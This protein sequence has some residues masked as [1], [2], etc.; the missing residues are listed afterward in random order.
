MMR[1]AP[2][3]VVAT[4]VCVSLWL[5]VG[6]TQHR[7]SRGTEYRPRFPADGERHPVGPGAQAAT[8]P[9]ATWGGPRS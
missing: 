3:V 8:A 4:Q 5:Q 1:M 6:A 7:D 2:Q 9:G